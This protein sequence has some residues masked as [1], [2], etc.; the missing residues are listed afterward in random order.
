MHKQRCTEVPKP[1][2][3]KLQRSQPSLD[4]SRSL[5][6][7]EPGYQTIGESMRLEDRSDLGT[8]WVDFSRGLFRLNRGLG[9]KSL[10][11][12]LSSSELN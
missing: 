7:Q 1:P 11:F 9:T 2:E 3:Q 4:W 8:N 10:R 6:A 5:P 12:C